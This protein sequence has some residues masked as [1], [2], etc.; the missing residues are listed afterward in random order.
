VVA[1]VFTPSNGLAAFTPNYAAVLFDGIGPNG[2]KRRVIVRRC[3]NTANLEMA[4]KKDKQLLVPV[5]FFSHFVS[6][7][8][9]PFSIAE[10]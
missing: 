4:Y 10:A 9:A 1:G 3:L 8:I 6:A 2:T 7:S 5:E